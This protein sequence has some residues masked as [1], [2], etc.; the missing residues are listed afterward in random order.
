MVVMVVGDQI[1]HYF[2][3]LL[4]ILTFSYFLKKEDD[5][6]VILL[7]GQAQGML[8]SLWSQARDFPV[9]HTY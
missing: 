1:H 8:D 4:E 2:H 5:V 3:V 9:P 6:F 7:N